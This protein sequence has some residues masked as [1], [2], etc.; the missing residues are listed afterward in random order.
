MIDIHAH[1]LPKLDD[2]ARDLSSALRMAELAVQSGVTAMVATPHSNMPMRFRNYWGDSLRRSIEEFRECL[3]EEGIPLEI[4]PGMEIFGTEETARLLQDG[5]LMT[6]AGSRYP[7]VEFPFVDYEHSATEILEEICAC[8]YRPVVA[9]PERYEYVQEN[10]EWIN[11]WVEL[12]CL[13]Q[14]NKGS[15]LGYFG[16]R[17]EA[18]AHSL[19]DRGFACVVASDAHSHTRRTP[20]MTD[21]WELLSEEYSA[22]TAQLLLQKNPERLVNDK[23]IDGMKPEWF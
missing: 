1:I 19:V 6:I 7:L 13:L 17:P 4:Y 3:Q 16:D 23:T 10:P 21:I 11:I 14:I 12:G 22:D 8:G 9:H 15:L 5:K 2:G 20:W 18:L